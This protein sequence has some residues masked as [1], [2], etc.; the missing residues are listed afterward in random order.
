M[1]R[2][3]ENPLTRK[4]RMFTELS[5]REVRWLDLA[6]A[7]MRTVEAD[8]ELVRPDSI[9]SQVFVL[10][11]G[12]AY[13]YKALPDGRRQVLNFVLPGD[14]MGLRAHFFGIADHS[15]VTLTDVTVSDLSAI[16]IA[17]LFQDFPKLAAAIT[18]SAAR[19][20]A[21]LAEHIVRLGRRNALERTAHLFLELLNRLRA[22]DMVRDNTFA[23]PITQ[24]ILADTLGLSVVHVNR[25]LRKLRVMGLV[26]IEG[27]RIFL[28]DIA[29]LERLAAYDSA[30]IAGKRTPPDTEKQLVDIEV[31]RAAH[32][33]ARIR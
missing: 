4:L 1:N 7:E 13:R 20:E 23:F 26:D 30:H 19:E 21:M 33:I 24:Q 9:G 15:I 25:T 3:A 27:G 22:V 5:E 16:D 32:R 29:R 8:V 31:E 10:Q 28:K 17:N 12:W 6:T 14:F 2:L 11:A 18:W